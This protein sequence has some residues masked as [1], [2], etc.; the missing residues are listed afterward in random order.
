MQTARTA[1]WP[2]ILDGLKSMTATYR[3]ARAEIEAHGGDIV[4]AKEALLSIAKKMKAM[5][6]QL[7]S[8]GQ[9]FRYRP[10]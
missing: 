10:G 9:A 1:A 2:T 6:G 3:V 5:Q 7:R 4:N 8:S